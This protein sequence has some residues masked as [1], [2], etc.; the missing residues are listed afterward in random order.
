MWWLGLSTGVLKKNFYNPYVFVLMSRVGF[1]EKKHKN[2]LGGGEMNKRKKR[3]LLIPNSVLTHIS[4]I[5]V[6]SLDS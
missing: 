5:G 4:P 2:P 6:K 3:S 1:L